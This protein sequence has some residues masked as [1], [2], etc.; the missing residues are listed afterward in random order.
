MNG[1]VLA[2]MLALS[3]NPEGVE[4]AKL[5]TRAEN[6]AKVAIERVM[7]LILEVPVVVGGVSLDRENE[8]MVL[9]D[10]RVANPDGF[11]ADYAFQAE[12]VQIEAD[13]ESLFTRT[14]QVK[15][16]HVTG[17]HIN[18]E[19]HL[20]KG[21]NLLRLRNNASKFQ[22]GP[23][24]AR[25]EKEWRIGQGVLE[26][27]KVN[28]RTELLESR[29]EE[30]ELERIEMTFGPEGVPAQ[31]AVQQF[32]VRIIEELDLIPENSPLAPVADVFKRLRDR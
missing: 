16:I 29:G 14:P 26:S 25:M 22:T 4:S 10:F 9:S 6:V 31:T 27:A 1:F 3:Q 19:T 12:T 24:R 18:A 21:S 23:L 8:L 17:A 5:P 15:V 32:I 7:S 20:R 30:K 11:H 28:M 13:L 2:L